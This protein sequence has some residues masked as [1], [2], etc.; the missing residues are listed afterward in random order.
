MRQV[1]W[2]KS[3]S[4]DFSAWGVTAVARS[5]QCSSLWLVRHRVLSC[6]LKE[7]P[8]RRELL[9]EKIDPGLGVQV[10][11]VRRNP[12]CQAYVNEWLSGSPRR[13]L[14]PSRRAASAWRFVL[15]RYPVLSWTS[16]DDFSRKD[17]WPCCVCPWGRTRYWPMLLRDGIRDFAWFREVG[18][19][20]RAVR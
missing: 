20:I 17:A 9:N 16:F 2:E 5:D 6:R 14:A 8:G 1:R 11:F 15:K 3:G 13:G 18:D 7:A 12:F 4:T 10:P 19:C